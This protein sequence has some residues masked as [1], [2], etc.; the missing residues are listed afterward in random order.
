[1]NSISTETVSQVWSDRDEQFFR[2]TAALFSTE[3]CYGASVLLASYDDDA[4]S[5]PQSSSTPNAAAD[6][7]QT[8]Q[9]LA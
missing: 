5:Q 8:H 3:F 2:I 9:V 4:G 6:F 7:T 1:M